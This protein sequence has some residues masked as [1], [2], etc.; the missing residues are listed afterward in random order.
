MR[1]LS[2]ARWLH[3][4]ARSFRPP[5]LCWLLLS[6]DQMQQQMQ[7]QLDQMQQQQMGMNGMGMP[8]QQLQQMGING[9]GMPMS[10]NVMGMPP[11]MAP[12]M[13]P[14]TPAQG[15][16]GMTMMGVE[17]GAVSAAGLNGPPQ[18]QLMV[19]NKANAEAPTS[20]FVPRQ[21]PQ[22]GFAGGLHPI[23][24][25]EPDCSFYVKTG[26]CKYGKT[27]KFNHPP[28]MLGVGAYRS[29]NASGDTTGDATPSAS[30]VVGDEHWV[31]HHMMSTFTPKAETQPCTIYV[32]NIGSGITSDQLTQF[33][34]S[35][36]CRAPLRPRA[37]LLAP[38]A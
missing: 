25:G 37:C 4:H 3:A 17:P 28:E 26:D 29:A 19:I 35:C 27:C 21:M 33:F 9:M 12:G 30:A 11:N 6:L 38:S 16:P 34:G 24:P 36:P 5:S 8:M 31:Y 15:P 7:Q 2:P 1:P 20:G 32:G 23:R 14:F 13:M 10:I 18:Q 22:S